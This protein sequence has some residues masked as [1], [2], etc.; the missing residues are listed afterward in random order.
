MMLM[1]LFA[2]SATTDLNDFVSD[3]L[4]QHKNRNEQKNSKRVEKCFNEI[5]VKSMKGLKGIRWPFE[6][7]QEN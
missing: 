2:Y 7:S 3:L 6:N 5:S 4:H 1:Q